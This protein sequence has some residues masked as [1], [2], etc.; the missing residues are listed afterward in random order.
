MV[1]KEPAA[2][3]SLTSRKQRAVEVANICTEAMQVPRNQETGAGTKSSPVALGARC[4]TCAWQD[5]AVL[6]VPVQI[7]A[8]LPVSH[9]ALWPLVL[10]LGRKSPRRWA[11]PR[12]PAWRAPEDWPHRGCFP[13]SN[14]LD[15]ADGQRHWCSQNRKES[16]LLPCMAFPRS[17]VSATL[18]TSSCPLPAS[19]ASS[20]SG[21]LCAQRVAVV[22]PATPH[23]YM[24]TFVIKKNNIT[25]SHL[26]TLAKSKAR[27]SSASRL[28]Q[29]GDMEHTACSQCC[30]PAPHLCLPRAAPAPGPLASSTPVTCRQ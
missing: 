15:G 7:P 13:S 22:L 25:C 3:Q 11:A 9:F 28:L 23:S 12:L 21:I 10:R 30:S 29:L 20:P 6:V 4:A 2:L 16:Q 27:M 24:G 26:G 19:H 8:T 14:T 5:R 1:S 17:R 18:Y